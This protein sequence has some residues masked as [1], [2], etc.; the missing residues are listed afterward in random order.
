MTKKFTFDRAFGPESRQSEVYQAVVSPLI[1]EVLAGY[2]CTV[3]AYGQTGTGKTH[4]MIGTECPE[5]KSSWEDVSCCFFSDNY[6]KIFLTF[7][8]K[9]C[10]FYSFSINDLEINLYYKG[11]NGWYYTTSIKSSF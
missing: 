1:E 11:I 9:F 3:F 8:F 4:T 6:M 2:N 7:Y 10:T 5:L